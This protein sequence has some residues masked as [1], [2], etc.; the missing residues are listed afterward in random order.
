MVEYVSVITATFLLAFEFACSK[1]Y[2]SLEGTSLQM[3]LRYNAVSGLTSAVFMWI[4]C[5]FRPEWSSYSLLLAFAMALSSMLYTLLSFQ[6]L[7]L[8]G[9]ALYSLALMSGGMLLPY[10]FGILFWNE[11]FTFAGFLG[12][13]AVLAAVILANLNRQT[14]NKPLLLLCFA[15]FILN[16]CC[17]I[18]S[19][20]HQINQTFVTTDSAGFVLYSG[21]WKCLLCAPILLVRKK[22]RASHPVSRIPSLSVIIGASVISAASYLLQLNGAKFLPASVLY[23]VITGGSVVFSAITGRVLFKECI[24]LR[25]ALCMLLCILGTWLLIK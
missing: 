6:I 12:L 21:V 25:Q 23:P 2:Q 4:L 19:K 1:K 5:G 18:L 14:V 3:G 9:I 11:S 24:S 13:V 8:G 10:V 17:S 20:T 15:V 22:P 7:K 16:G